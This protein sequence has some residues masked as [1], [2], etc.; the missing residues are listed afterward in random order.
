MSKIIVTFDLN[1]SDNP[2]FHNSK[3]KFAEKLLNYFN[4]RLDLEISLTYTENFEF[5][6][7][8]YTNDDY[9]CASFVENSTCW[10]VQERSN[11]SKWLYG[12]LSVKRNLVD[13]IKSP[14]YA[15]LQ[16]NNLRQADIDFFRYQKDKFKALYKDFDCFDFLSNENKEKLKLSLNNLCDELDEIV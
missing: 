13:N 1:K 15:S 2:V 3:L 10:F 14:F 12:F 5:K 11:D 7:I 16:M 8:N 9:N 6:H 4:S